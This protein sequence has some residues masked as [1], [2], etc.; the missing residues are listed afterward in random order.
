M[1]RVQAVETYRSRDE[2]KYERE[3]RAAQGLGISGELSSLVDEIEQLGGIWEDRTRT[4]YMPDQQSIDRLAKKHRFEPRWDRNRNKWWFNS[5]VLIE[6]PAELTKALRAL[7]KRAWAKW[8]GKVWRLPVQKLNGLRNDLDAK[9]VQYEFDEESR[10][11]GEAGVLRLKSMGPAQEKRRPYTSDQW[12]RMMDI[13]RDVG[14]EAQ[15][16]IFKKH[17]LPPGPL[18]AIKRMKAFDREQLG[19][20]YADFIQETVRSRASVEMKR[21]VIAELL[22][23][24]QPRLANAVAMWVAAKLMPVQEALNWLDMD[25]EK[26]GDPAVLKKA[27]RDASMKHHPDRGGT[28]EAMQKVNEAYEVLRKQ[29]GGFRSPADRAEQDLK[30]EQAATIMEQGLRNAFN[31]QK[32][33]DHIEKATGKKFRATSKITRDKTYYGYNV[34]LLAEWKSEDGL[35]T[36]ELRAWAD[37]DRFNWGPRQLGA[38]GQ[39]YSFQVSAYSRIFHETR[40]V[41]FKQSDW[42]ASSDSRV[43]LDPKSM[44]PASKIKQMMTGKEKKR[45]FSKRDML[46]GLEKLVGAKVWRSGKDDIADVPLGKDDGFTLQM[47]RMTMMVTALWILS[48]NLWQG[49]I[50]YKGS[51]PHKQRGKDLLEHEAALKL[52]VDLRKKSASIDD[53]AKLVSLVE[54]MTGQFYR[55]W[56][57]GK[58]N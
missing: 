32:F 28:K 8:D 1:M 35:T 53:P 44:F 4:W 55:D 58:F 26:L 54:Q 12:R 17:G 15:E 47:R 11:E 30:A 25:A 14:P 9:N 19:D 27:Y 42:A 22:R 50:G 6:G 16:R 52:L 45:K 51:V 23:A 29:K 37:A 10:Y 46:L 7:F 2:E 36:F 20:L 24:R 13:M 18:S 3:R 34:R 48:Q 31:E 21:A 40:K 41:K 43:V 38:G 39:D 33:T 56:Q 49:K 57:A 5:L